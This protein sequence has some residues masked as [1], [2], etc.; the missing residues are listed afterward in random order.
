M[1]R[2]RDLVPAHALLTVTMGNV[3]TNN[4]RT[5]LPGIF[6]LGRVVDYKILRMEG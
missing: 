2:S 5:D 4:S 3:M 1:H 6:K